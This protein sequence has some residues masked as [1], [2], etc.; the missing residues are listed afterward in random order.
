MELHELNRAF[1]QFSPTQEQKEAMCRRLLEP[2]PPKKP[3]SRRKKIPVVL[4]AAAAILAA[5]GAAAV[6]TGFGS[7]I[8]DYFGVPEEETDLFSQEWVPVGQS[9]TFRNGWTVE[10]QQMYTGLYSAGLLVDVTAPEGVVLDG[11][12]Y[13]LGCYWDETALWP[14]RIGGQSVDYIPDS[15]PDDGRVS[16]LVTIDSTTEDPAS[17]LGLETEFYPYR[18]TEISTDDGTEQT[19]DFVGGSWTVDL[20]FTLSERASGF[21][22]RV[23]RPL[24]AGGEEVILEEVYLSPLS[25]CY[26]IRT[27]EG[28]PFSGTAWDACTPAY[29]APVVLTLRSGETVALDSF[30]NGWAQRT[31]TSGY[32]FAQTGYRPER[33]FNPEQVVSLTILGQTFPLDQLTP[34]ES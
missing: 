2:E 5:S 34:V 26:S 22:Q 17:L 14:N 23:D 6:T 33:V 8:L 13:S 3:H 29:N 24:T 18:L 16:F 7:H 31:D 32:T 11:D 27:Q 21:L 9:H 12:I 19:F 25:V 20:D 4:A 15:A 28:V 10:V 1:D 30:L